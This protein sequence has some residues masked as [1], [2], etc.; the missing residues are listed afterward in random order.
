MPSEEFDRLKNQNGNLVCIEDRDFLKK[1]RISAELEGDQVVLH[2]MD[3]LTAD[4]TWSVSLDAS[5]LTL[6]S[7]NFI[8]GDG[9]LNFDMDRAGTTTTAGYIQ[10]SDMTA[11]DLTDYEHSGSIFVYLYAPTVSGGL[12]GFTLRVGSDAS[13]YFSKQVTVTN[14]NLA[15]HTGWMVLRFDFNSATETGTV[16]IE[17]IDYIRLAVDRGALG[18]LDST[19]WRVDYIV[20]RRGIPHEV[21]YY[22]KYGWQTSAGAYLENSTANSDLLNADTEEYGL[23][24]LKGKQFLAE[25]LGFDEKAASYAKQFEA[26]KQ[27]YTNNYPSERLLLMTEYYS[28]SSLSQSSDIDDDD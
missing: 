5:N 11:V 20:A 15:L 18:S 26:K 27:I 3:S 9:S 7:D 28:F 16:D 19:D 13:N 24:V 1:L 4:G 25:D 17:N 10:N 12:D 22:T 14:E 6:D 2:E 21:W 8:N 23:F